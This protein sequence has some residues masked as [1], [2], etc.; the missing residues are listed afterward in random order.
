MPDNATKRRAKTTA[1]EREKRILKI[2]DLLLEGK[3]RPQILEYCST[4]YG[5]QRAAGDVLIQQAS[6]VI[7]EDLESRREAIL[8]DILAK[9]ERI[10]TET[11]TIQNHAVARLVLMDK[12]KLVGIEKQRVV[13]S[14]EV[15]P[16][17]AALT[18]EELDAKLMGMSE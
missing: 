18:D 11:M 1:A 12:A 2:H 17:I 16:E 15:A 14:L 3:S 8:A 4:E 7:R 13:H 10:Y 5:M 9:Q 6:K